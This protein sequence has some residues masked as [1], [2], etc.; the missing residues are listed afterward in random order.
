[1]IMYKYEKF[2]LRNYR[3]WKDFSEQMLVMFFKLLEY[4]TAH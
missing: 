3:Q 4:N 1:M 2:Y